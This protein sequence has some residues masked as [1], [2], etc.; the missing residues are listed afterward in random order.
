MGDRNC[1][2]PAPQTA[3][4]VSASLGPVMLLCLELFVD[5]VRSRPLEWTLPRLLSVLSSLSIC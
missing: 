3:E 1:G 2:S 4:S 5:A